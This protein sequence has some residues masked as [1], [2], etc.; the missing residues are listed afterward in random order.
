[1]LRKYLTYIFV[2]NTT[3]PKRWAYLAKK[4]SDE[5]CRIS[6]ED[7]MKLGLWYDP[8][9]GGVYNNNTTPEKILKRSKQGDVINWQIQRYKTSKGASET[10]VALLLNEERVGKPVTL[11]DNKFYPTIFIASSGAK[12]QLEVKGAFNSQRSNIEPSI[13]LIGRLELSPGKNV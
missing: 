13:K 2:K 8:F 6:R 12:L 3:T 11:K 1:M 10:N 9:N 7:R 5:D 4:I